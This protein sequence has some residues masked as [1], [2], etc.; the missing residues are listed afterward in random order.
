MNKNLIL[1]S[2]IALFLVASCL[3]KPAVIEKPV[4]AK[5]GNFLSLVAER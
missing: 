4:E 5:K 1:F 2:V 3:P